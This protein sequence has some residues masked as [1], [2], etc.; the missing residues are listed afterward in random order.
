MGYNRLKKKVEKFEKETNNLTVPDEY[1]FEDLNN[2]QYIL[3]RKKEKLKTKENE[4][5]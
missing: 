3:Y 5:I 4:E 2:K 1:S